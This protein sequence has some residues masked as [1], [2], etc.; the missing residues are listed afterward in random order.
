MGREVASLRIDKK[1][2]VANLK[3]NCT[4]Y[5]TVDI[6]GSEALGRDANIEDC[7]EKQ[8][9]LSVKITNCEAG[10]PEGKVVKADTLKLSDKKSNSTVK[11][12]SESAIVDATLDTNPDM[13]KSPGPGLV[14]KHH[15]NGVEA[16][17][18]GSNCSSKSNDLHSPLSAKRSQQTP[19]VSR[20]LQQLDDRK[21]HDEE[22]I[23]SLASSLYSAAASVRTLRSK[24]TVPVAPT[25]KS[26]DRA[27][28]RREF[29]SK[30]EEKHKALE[31]EKQEC[32]ARTKEEEEA[33]IKQL[34]KNM[35]YKANPVPSFYHE[36][37]PPKAELKKLPLTRAKS[38]NLT[39]RKSCSD[40]VVSPEVKQVCGR[41]RHSIG[42]YR[43]GNTSAVTPKSK[44]PVNG[45]NGN[46]TSSAKPVKVT[47]R[48][49]AKGRKETPAN[50]SP[51]KE[52]N[53]SPTNDVKETPAE[54][55]KESNCAVIDFQASGHI[56]AQS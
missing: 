23:W 1:A 12:A 2:N 24:I 13:L 52:T 44:G 39:R 48:T 47:R 3:P 21:H 14:A 42:A 46:G 43:Q 32:A 31:A 18:T 27:A 37:P 41:G 38:P 16:T 17:D 26:A 50:D 6:N 15:A 40:A 55:V 25:F 33:V 9:V 20:K 54:E 5:G 45:E 56:A 7:R 36:G 11:P 19:L 4:G 51:A 30:L 34:R 22:D 49:P 28:R 10:E 8:D 29:Y 53:A 35:V